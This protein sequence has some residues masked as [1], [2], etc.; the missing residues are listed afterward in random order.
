MSGPGAD[1]DGDGVPLRQALEA[2]LMVVEDPVPPA[3]LGRVLGRPA[4][5]VAR[6]LRALA[7]EYDE[8]RRGFELREVGG[9]WRFYSRA[10]CAGVVERFVLD[11]QSA[12]L[13]QAALETLAVLAYQ[14]PVTRGR[15]AAVRGVAVDGV[16]R[17]L[18]A[19]GLVEEA[20]MEPGSGALLYRT[21]GRF[22]ERLGLGSL[23]EL[24]ALAPLL[25]G[26]EAT[27]A[28]GEQHA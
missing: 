4:A 12:R 19:R 14:Q 21:T 23:E 25:P 17:T 6:E 9:G 16:M 7:G 22:L 18:L 2:V 20:G 3:A 8:Q 26:P 24:P 5:E 10:A 28:L 13:S 1:G 15:I 27:D 11:G